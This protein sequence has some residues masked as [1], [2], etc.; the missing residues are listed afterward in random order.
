MNKSIEIPIFINKAYSL[1]GGLYK[2][3]N[4]SIDKFNKSN[5]LLMYFV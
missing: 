5:S 2:E 4:N 3:T 1:Q